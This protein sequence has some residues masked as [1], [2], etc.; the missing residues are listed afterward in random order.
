MKIVNV[1]ELCR[2]DG[3]LVALY[4]QKFVLRVN[5]LKN[6]LYLDSFPLEACIDI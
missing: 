4:D 3:I 1:E 5:S 2:Y 6:A